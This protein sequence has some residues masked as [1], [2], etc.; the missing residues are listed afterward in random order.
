MLTRNTARLRALFIAFATV[1]SLS[2]DGTSVAAQ[3]PAAEI[4]TAGSALA[5]QYCYAC[6]GVKFNGSPELNILNPETL[7]EH[8]YLDPGSVEDSVLWQRIRDDEMPPDK[9]GVARPNDQEKAVLKQWLAAGAP[10][11]SQT[12][13]ART[14]LATRDVVLEIR[15][16]LEQAPVQDQRFL[17]YF[18]LINLHNDTQHVTDA[19]LRLARAALSKAIN[20][21]SWERAMVLP[22]AIDA[23][24]SI[25]VVDLRELGWTTELWKQIV[26][27]YP[28]GLRFNDPRDSELRDADQRIY[29]MTGNTLAWLRADWFISSATRPPLYHDILQLP[30]SDS[31]LERKLNVDVRQNYQLDRL[32]R[33]GF[34]GSG[35]SIGNRMVERHPASYGYYWKSYDFRQG[36]E[37]GNLFQF[38]LG[39][40]SV[41]DDHPQ[42]SFLHDGGEIIFSLPNGLQAY[43]LVDE[44]GKQI[45]EGPADVVRDLK[46]IGGST[47]VVNGVSCMHCH[48]EGMISEFKDSVRSGTA[49]RGEALDKVSRIYPT[50]D[51]MRELLQRDRAQFLAA[52]ELATGQFLRTSEEAGRAIESYPEPVG[53]V[54]T[55]YQRDLSLE[56]AAYELGLSDVNEL[57]NAVRLSTELSNAGLGPLG[58]GRTIKRAEWERR[59]TRL[60]PTP[61]QKAALI[62]INASPFTSL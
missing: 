56:D 55:R 8:G 24:E 17:R 59:Q 45:P 57:K 53:S 38:P 30:T 7:R 6:H 40:T 14:A 50:F 3:E 4:A 5:K 52:V 51:R 22:E 54:V 31:E 62:L 46:E 29:E 44:K 27:Q 12:P 15:K 1:I 42:L 19:D 21:L 58:T 13:A 32:Q 36:K 18:S 47:V 34:A 43:L 37:R 48:A 33:A 35:V 9:P 11:P 16:H 2:L 26:K 23:A 39:P 10:L 28:Y 60:S 20:S 49:V 61:F 41:S 25:Y